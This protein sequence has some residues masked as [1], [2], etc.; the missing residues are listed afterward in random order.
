VATLAWADADDDD[1]DDREDEVEHRRTAAPPAPLPGEAAYR[2]ECGSCHL[3]YP[4]GMLPAASWAK[5][6]GGLA[7]H[8]G[9][10]A[11]VDEDALRR[12]SDWLRRNAAES[13]SHPLSGRVL[14]SLSG[15]TPLRLMDVPFMKREHDEL[16]PAVYRRE[17]VKS[18]ANCGA[19]HLAAERWEF[20]ERGVKIPRG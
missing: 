16:R 7:D 20:D 6:M 3:A 15:Q 1:D 4:P 17:S 8:F 2:R 14:R 12:L 19:C 18:R 5:L 11:E 9:Q 13:G 10:N